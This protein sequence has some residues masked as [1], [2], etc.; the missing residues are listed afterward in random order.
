MPQIHER[1]HI[2]IHYEEVPKDRRDA[3]A[4]RSLLDGIDAV[5][6]V[7]IKGGNRYSWLDKERLCAALGQ[8]EQPEQSISD[9]KRP[10]LNAE[11]FEKF[12]EDPLW[13]WDKD[14]RSIQAA[15]LFASTRGEFLKGI[16]PL[17]Q[18]FMDMLDDRA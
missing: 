2:H 5:I 17:F 13:D 4:L 10:A 15:L 11:R 14:I 3:Q 12:L 1:P 9:E 8:E 7:H 6:H 16:E 18:M